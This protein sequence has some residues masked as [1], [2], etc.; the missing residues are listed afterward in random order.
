MPQMNDLIL[1]RQET[2]RHRR[3]LYACLGVVALL[4]VGSIGSLPGLIAIGAIGATALGLMGAQHLIS[5]RLGETYVS[6]HPAGR[7][8]IGP[9]S[10]LWD[11]VL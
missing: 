6:P 1:R 2:R 7:E 10:G 3:V 11:N 5:R 4:V 9:A 8:A